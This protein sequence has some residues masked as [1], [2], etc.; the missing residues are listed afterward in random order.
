MSGTYTLT[1]TSP[2]GCGSSSSVT[3]SV[4][5]QPT[6]TAGAA[7]TIICEGESIQV[8]NNTYNQ[9]GFYVDSLLSAKGCDSI[10]Q[11]ELM[12]LPI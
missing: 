11:L 5:Q 4:S 12:V 3:I 8:G 6:V 1:V 2:A 10:V 9:S 7:N